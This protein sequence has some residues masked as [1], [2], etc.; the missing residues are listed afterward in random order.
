MRRAQSFVPTAKTAPAGLGASDALL[1]RA[2][3]MRPAGAH[4]LVALPL[5]A[6]VLGKLRA[7]LEHELAAI[8]AVAIARPSVVSA[9]IHRGHPFGEA[10]LR[11]TD[12]RRASHVLAPSHVTV[13]SEVAR[14]ELRGFRDLPRTFVST[15]PSLS[16]VGGLHERETVDGC[17]F[18]ANALDATHA[19]RE[20]S[21]AV[22]R[23][24]AWA[25]LPARAHGGAGGA[26]VVHVASKDGEE[27]LVCAACGGAARATEA[28][29]TCRD[30]RRAPGPGRSKVHTPDAKSIGEVARFL[31]VDE[32]RL[33]K[34]LLYRAN[35]ATVM[36][37]VRGDHDVNEARLALVLGASEVTLADADEVQRAT[38]ARVGFAGPVGFRGRVLVDSFA[39]VVGDAVVG[40]NEDDHHVRD[41]AY[42]RDFDG[43]IVDVRRA[44][45]GDSCPSCEGGALAKERGHVLAQ[46]RALDPRVTEGWGVTYIDPAQKKTATIV[47]ETRIDLSA[48]LSAIVERGSVNDA[49]AWPSVLAPFDVQLVSLGGEAEI[50]AAADALYT[51][52]RAE[53]LDVMWDDRDDKPGSKLKDAELMGIPLRIAIGKRSLTTSSAEVWVRA[54]GDTTLV[55]LVDV[56]RFVGR[57]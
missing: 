10:P 49:L 23:V 33:L 26:F 2:G 51:E 44:V 48:V 53:G 47:T 36:V 24:L 32:R 57:P 3:Y 18:F 46:G 40:A 27:L 11:V 55:P 50:C 25:H 20:T 43:E 19:L 13:A 52:L 41:V 28:S 6:R 21:D 56:A 37:V 38:G 29:T 42:G 39:A 34:S 45:V 8:G 35:G 16:R 12:E 31:A 1:V 5:G 14:H 15:G 4:G 54:T 22:V 9:E 30:P 7:K 17:G